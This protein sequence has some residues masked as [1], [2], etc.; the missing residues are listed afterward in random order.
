M[1]RILTP[2]ICVIGAGSGGLS[3]A[4]AAAGF[5]VD[6]VLIEKGKMGGDCLNTGCVPSKALI[7]AAGRAQIMRSSG[8]FGISPHEPDVDYGKV[9]DHIQSVIG[10]IAPHDSV[11]RFTGLGV[12][13]IKAAGAF[14]DADTVEAGDVRVRARRFVVATGSSAGVPPIAGLKDTPFYTNENLFDAKTLPEHLIV[15]GGGPIGMEMAQAHRRL[16]SRVTVLEMFAPLGK[17]D[18]ELSAIILEQIRSE[19][20]DIRGGVKIIEVSKAGSGVRVSLEED[21]K[22]TVIE[23]SH[24]LVAAGRIPNVENLGLEKAGIAHDRRGIRVDAGLRSS[25]RR[26]YAIGDVAGHFQFTHVANYHAGI[27]IR[28]ILFRMPAKISDT[29]IPWVT[30]T[31][32]ELAHVGLSEAAARKV[33]GENIKVLRWPFAENDR[34]IALRQTRGLVKVVTSRRGRIL[35]AAIAGPE[36]GEIIQPWVLAISAKMN[37]KAMTGAIAPYPTLSEVNKRAAISFYHDKM[38]NPWLGRL[39]RFLARFG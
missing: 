14:V 16:G 11:E 24:L 29:A 36:A 7:A 19:G 13:V 9:H 26:V 2:D 23:G 38:T 37:I 8:E 15:I 22:N 25:N 28:A 6:V 17:D 31:D 21:G 3:V 20:V 4:A 27:V 34:A 33:L 10:E 30:Y 32:P 35:G 12:T 39:I 5:G 18:P 1:S